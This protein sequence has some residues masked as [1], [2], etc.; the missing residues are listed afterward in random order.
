MPPFLK[1][2]N[3]PKTLSELKE[4][5]YK[6]ETVK[7]EI[8]RN[9]IE[10]IRTGN[11][12]FPGITGY[13]DTVIPGIENAV[14]SGHDMILL[15]ERGQAKT[16]II[17]SLVNFLDERIPAVQGCEINDN[18][19]NPVCRQCRNLI[20]EHRGTTPITWIPRNLRYSEKLATPDVTISDLIGDIDPVK[21]AQGRHLSDEL[22][23]HYGLIPRS[24]RG[25]FSINEIPDL[26][27][28][29]QVG[30][31][32]LL[33][34]RDIQIRGYKVSLP[35]DLFIVATANPEDYTSRG[36]IITP[37]KDRFGAQIRTHYP[38]TRE[39]E[40]SIVRNEIKSFEQEQI[41]TIVPHFMEQIISSISHIA[42]KSP[43]INQCSGISVRMS[44]HNME[45]IISNSL[46]RSIRLKEPEA[47]P[48]I[49]DLSYITASMQAKIEWIFTESFDQPEKAE[50]I[51]REAVLQAFKQNFSPALFQPFL[52]E[53]ARSSGWE[54]SEITPSGAYSDMLDKYPELKKIIHSCG[55]SSPAIA[56]STAEFI[57]EALSITGKLKKQ[58]KDRKTFYDT[59]K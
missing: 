40:I 20:E 31:F 58:V 30:L 33:E 6:P 55:S 37:L 18:P 15:G 51:I 12:L 23:V 3:L 29:I 45:T 47:V 24:N 9:L 44:I 7:A 49:S 41:L 36:R 22:A 17:R 35:L 54:V 59:A 28:K 14:L 1:T 57:L 34:E 8:R 39:Q 26:H 2:M 50:N 53:F 25:I 42:R 48:R 16:R 21:V 43:D 46:R 19:L 56:S 52:K 10:K 13:R 32:N 38:K 27:E 11:E 5:G 4:S